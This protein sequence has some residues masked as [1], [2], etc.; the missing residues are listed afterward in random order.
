MKSTP[1]LIVMPTLARGG[2]ER[3]AALIATQLD[4]ERWR[5]HVLAFN[6]GPL[7]G[8]LADHGV[9]VVV[10]PVPGGRSKIPA[11]AAACSRE[12]GSPHSVTYS[13]S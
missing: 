6:D 13:Y 9:P 8:I 11:A 12:V 4:Y 1:L 3:H 7:H 10:A 2:A 5:P